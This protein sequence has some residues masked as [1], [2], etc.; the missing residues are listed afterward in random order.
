MT[1]S[2]W[3]VV[4]PESVENT[5]LVFGRSDVVGMVVAVCEGSSFSS[6][7]QM[8]DRIDEG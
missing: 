3:Y 4:I 1:K 7:F 6:P 2:N 5:R 8:K